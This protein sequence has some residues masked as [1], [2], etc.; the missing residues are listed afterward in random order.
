VQLET[1]EQ[2]RANADRIEAQLESNAMPPG[3]TTGMTDEE[4]AQLIAWAAAAG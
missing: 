1:A 2:L 4:R 3:N